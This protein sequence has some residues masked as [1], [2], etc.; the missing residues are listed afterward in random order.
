MY[1]KSASTLYSAKHCKLWHLLFFPFSGMY[2]LSTSNI[3]CA[4]GP[5]FAASPPLLVEADVLMSL[6]PSLLVGKDVIGVAA[7]DTSR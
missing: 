2:G 4:L 7:G 3:I 6:G 5:R 1:K